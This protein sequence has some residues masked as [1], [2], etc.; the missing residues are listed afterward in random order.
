MEAIKKAYYN[1]FLF[2]VI[3]FFVNNFIPFVKKCFFDSFIMAFYRW[4]DKNI[5]KS[6]PIKL[7]FDTKFITEIWYES[8][9][10]KA[11]TL[12]IRKASYHFPKS[13]LPFKNIYIGI[14]IAITMLVPNRLW[15]D[16]FWI[17][18][19]FAMVLLYLSRNIKNRAGTIFAL[20]NVVLLIFL[21]LIEIAVSYSVAT[22]IVYL[23]VGIDLFFLLSLSIKSREDL[24]EFIQPLFIASL[25][26]FLI[27]LVSRIMS[28]EASTFLK[29]E[30]RIGEILMFVFPF[31][32]LYPLEYLEN[33]K[34]TIYEA[35]IFVAF[36]TMIS[37][38]QSRT[39]LIGFIAEIVVFIIF[40]IKKL[41]LLAV[42]SPLG[43]STLI[44]NAKST[45][46][47]TTN[48]GNIFQNIISL[49]QKIWSFGFGVDRNRLMSF[50][51]IS[52]L[53][54]Q[55][56][57]LSMGITAGLSQFYI[58]FVIELGSLFMLIFLAYILR[59]AHSSL[60]MIFTGDKKYRKL[61]VAGL[62]VLL[63]ISVSS[64]FETTIFTSRVMLVYWAM[65]G[66][67]RAV[68]IMNIGITE[69]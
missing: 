37:A 58:D 6:K 4:I 16:M 9:F 5:I 33:P 10:Y 30:I 24:K 3:K 15:N 20:V 29:N 51:N 13:F 45:W 21:F 49:S 64:F 55:S 23:I 54:K 67:I 28:G 32:F 36:L 2:Y 34:K 43:L 52:E 46:Y 60:T 19:F 35:V 25:L 50:Y 68:R 27:C 11:S 40:D 44:E 42:L 69:S 38:T 62:A 12:R 47:A 22:F 39:A 63:G 61:V 31:V 48:Y 56:K 17:S 59:L 18:L 1:S 14:F 26:L 65:L 41:P 66:V 7:I 57:G 53:S 8:F